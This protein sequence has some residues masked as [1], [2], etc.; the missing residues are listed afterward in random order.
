MDE[1]WKEIEEYPNYEVSNLGRVRTTKY[2]SNAQKKYYDRILVLKQKTNRWG[3]NHVGLSNKN[4]RK[5]KIIHRLVAQAFISNPNNYLE[6]NHKDG[7][8]QN[9]CVDNLEWCNRSYNILHAYK[10][11]LK[12][13]IQE[14]IRLKKEAQN[15]KNK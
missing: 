12:K 11:G 6:I 3:Y 2:Y 5:S 4:G 13:P 1:I 9:N 7:N 14:Y 15:G 8:K 10:I